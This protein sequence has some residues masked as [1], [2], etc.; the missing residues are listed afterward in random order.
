MNQ[1][2]K[3]TLPASLLT[4]VGL[5]SSGSAMAI[6]CPAALNFFNLDVATKTIQL[7]GSGFSASYSAE[8][9]VIIA[10]LAEQTFQPDVMVVTYT[11]DGTTCLSGNIQ[12]ASF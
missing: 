12:A 9:P 5:S 3:Q 2:I 1:L 8:N 11:L 10:L 7:T 4:L 6:Q